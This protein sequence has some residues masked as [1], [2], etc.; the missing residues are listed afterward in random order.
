MIKKSV[1]TQ[2]KFDNKV[3]LIP[4]ALLIAL[5]SFVGGSKYQKS[6]NKVPEQENSSNTQIQSLPTKGTVKRVIDGDTIE[7]TTGQIVRYV[8]ITAPETGEPF[9][10][11]ATEENKRL[12]EGKKVTL[13]YDSE[14]YTSDKFGRILAYVIVDGKNVSIELARKGLDRVVIYQKRKQFIYQEVLLKAQEEAQ[15]NHRGIWK[16]GG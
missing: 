5:L 7:L 4:T 13:E 14:N 1:K 11:E 8:G 15:K 3:V 9:E 16:L 6:I 12:V 2:L 10:E